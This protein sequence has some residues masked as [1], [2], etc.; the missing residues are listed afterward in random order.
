MHI[1]PLA[2]YPVHSSL[3]CY[4]P[5]EGSSEKGRKHLKLTWETSK[6]DFLSL[7]VTIHRWLNKDLMR[8]VYLAILRLGSK[9]QQFRCKVMI[10]QWT[11]TV[12]CSQTDFTWLCIV[13]INFSIFIYLRCHI[14]EQ[15]SL[16]AV[17]LR[18]T[19]VACCSH[20][21]TVKPTSF[22]VRIFSPAENIPVL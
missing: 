3:M 9:H 2:K 21:T 15:K 8:Q 11:F 18:E 10:S 14:W 6:S 16:F 5:E 4:M 19:M 1:K 20:V 22:V 17:F 13:L 12:S 7:T